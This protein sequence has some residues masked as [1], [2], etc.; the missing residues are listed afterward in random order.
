MSSFIFKSYKL[1]ES[2]DAAMVSFALYPESLS[3]WFV[4]L[5]CSAKRISYSKHGFVTKI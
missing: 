5:Q 1:S 2:P 3:L 4:S